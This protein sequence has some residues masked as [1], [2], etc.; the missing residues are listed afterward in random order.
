M[1]REDGEAGGGLAATL[2]AHRGEL[3]RFLAARCGD[4][5]EAEDLI[6]DLW[7]KAGAQPATP[8][9]NP[10]AYLFRMAN[11][12]VLDQRRARRRAM[13]RDRGWLEAD[14][15]PAHAVQD[16]AD[17]AEPTDEALAREQEAALVRQAIADLPPGA[18]RAL[19]MFRIE[20]RSHAEIAQ[21]LG[22]SRSGVEK[23]LARAMKMLRAALADCGFFGPA[24]SPRQARPDGTMPGTED[25]P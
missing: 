2:A 7:F 4:A 18:R 15:I 1:G 19:E 3:L 23:N 6:Q 10:R 9:A 22:I 16:R 20:G 13:A 12:L 24:A 5:A 11:N 8:V 14:G 17:P 25:G 21:E